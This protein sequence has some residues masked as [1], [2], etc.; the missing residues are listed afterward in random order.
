MP[1]E[2]YF[3]GRGLE[4]L[5]KMKKKYGEKKGEEVF[6]ATARKQGMRSKVRG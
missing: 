4:V 5:K 3:K 6:Y 2:G 1:I